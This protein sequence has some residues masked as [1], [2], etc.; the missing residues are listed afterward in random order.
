[1]VAANR[2]PEPQMWPGM[3]DALD[4]AQGIPVLKMTTEQRQEKLFQ[5]LDL[6]GL[7][8]WS[9]EWA[10]SAHSLLTEYHNILSLESCKLG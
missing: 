5:K 8:S 9:P 1:M 6:S 2:M 4:K 7:G 3:I 10:E